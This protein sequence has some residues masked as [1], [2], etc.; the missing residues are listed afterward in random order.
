MHMYRVIQELTQQ[1]LPIEDSYAAPCEEKA[2]DPAEDRVGG[3]TV[4]ICTMPDG[5]DGPHVAT[6]DAESITYIGLAWTN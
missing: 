4:W 2:T 3:R 1:P 5:H 6:Y